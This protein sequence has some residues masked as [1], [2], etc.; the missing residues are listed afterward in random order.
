MR[1]RS[2]ALGSALAL[3]GLVG[4][5]ATVLFLTGVTS[6]LGE[7]GTER[8][9]AYVLPIGLALAGGALLTARPG[10]REPAR[11]APRADRAARA[12]RRPRR[13]RSAGATAPA[14]AWAADPSERSDP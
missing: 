2:E 11:P 10:G 4:T 5:A 13:R 12:P 1:P 3:L 14:T 7:G 8:V 6:Y 9:A